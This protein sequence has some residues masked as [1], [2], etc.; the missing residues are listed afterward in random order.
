MTSV[1]RARTFLN[2]IGVDTH[3]SYTDGGYNNVAN[4]IYDLKYI[5]IS[6]VRDSLT[7][8]THLAAFEA[9]AASGVTFTLNIGTGTQT[10]ATLDATLILDQSL[11]AF[12][13]GDL[14]A[15]EGANEIN[16]WAVS[17]NGVQGLAGALGL[18]GDLYE[19]VHGSSAFAGVGVDYFTG[20]GVGAIAAGP[21]PNLTGGLADFDT[22]H[23][24]PVD[25]KAPYSFMNP[26]NALNNE[27]GAVGPAVYTETGYS[28]NGG[29]TGAVNQDVQAKYTLDLICDAVK[30][31]VKSVFL[32]DLL[33]AYALGSKQG[34]DGYGLFDSN[35]QPKEVATALHNFTTLL[36]DPGA[37]AATFA[38]GVLKPTVQGLSYAG[39]DL[40]L[41]KSSGEFDVLVWDEPSLWIEAKGIERQVAARTVTVNLGATFQEVD[42]YDP[43][44]GTSAIET[45]HN[46]QTLQVSVTDHPLILE[47][48]TAS[49]LAASHA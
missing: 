15:V 47:V 12:M 48:F 14:L 7:K 23:P 13:P 2:A 38:P 16:N 44:K 26:A 17:Y 6:N 4:V 22:Q 41:Q 19:D 37:G 40:V 18:Q 29:T 10:T 28:S 11:L 24:Y 45:F 39:G 46:V 20:Y 49:A 31:G 3:L 34:D 32:Y 9:V 33:D 25:G 27:T 8:A 35:N 1:I 42:V 5:G 30:D 36:A 43:L 21:N